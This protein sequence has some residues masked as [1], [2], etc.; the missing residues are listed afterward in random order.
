MHANTRPFVQQGE[1]Y[2][3]EALREGCMPTLVTWLSITHSGDDNLEPSKVFKNQESIIEVH[4]RF[5][6]FHTQGHQGGQLTRPDGLFSK[7][8]SISHNFF[9][10]KGKKG[11]FNSHVLMGCFPNFDVWKLSVSHLFLRMLT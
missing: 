10:P 1:S 6:H 2:S 9:T 3:S 11:G 7:I 4:F 8:S 5:T